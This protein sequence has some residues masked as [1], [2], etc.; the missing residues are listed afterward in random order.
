MLQLFFRFPDK[1]YTTLSYRAP[2]PT[3]LVNDGTHSIGVLAAPEEF[4]FSP[5][6][7]F[8]N[9]RFGILIRNYSGGVQ[10]QLFAPVLGGTGS[11]MKAGDNYDFSMFLLAEELDITYAFEQIARER[12]G[13][14]DYRHNDI[15]SLNQT[16]DNIVDYAMSDYAWFVDSLKGCAYSTD[17]PGAV[18]N[19]SSLNPLELAIVTDDS[20]IFE[21]RAYPVLEYMLSREKF[22]FLLIQP[23]RYSTPQENCMVLLHQYQN[24]VHS[25]VFSTEIVVI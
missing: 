11:Q 19:V 8:A 15:A 14:R 4:N 20:Q 22:L 6:P 3:T 1:P 21:E 16:F 23:R 9:S 5:L 7:T 24:W 18:K 25:I 17:V 2:V 12:F 10:P 13:F